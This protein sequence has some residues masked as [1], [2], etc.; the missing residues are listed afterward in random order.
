MMLLQFREGGC[1]PPVNAAKELSGLVLELIEIGAYW[2]TTDGHASL[3]HVAR[4]A[5]G[6]VRRFE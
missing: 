1:V 2:K 3:L 4:S 5:D 6:R